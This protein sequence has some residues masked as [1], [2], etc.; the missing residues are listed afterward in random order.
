[1]TPALPLSSSTTAQQLTA[2]LSLSPGSTYHYRLVASNLLATVDGA[3]QAFTIPP[4]PPL[5]RVLKHARLASLLRHGLRLRVSDSS[6][7][8][9]AVKLQVDAESARAAH[10]IPPKSKRKAKVTIG[11]L[12]VTVA[13]NRGKT[14]TVK[15]AGAARRNLA[16]LGRIK[17]TISATA[18]TPNGV[19][20]SP[21]SIAAR[22]VR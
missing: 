18:S 11:S 17:L 19:A 6:R 3:D 15:F 12:R 9:I 4:E 2:T 22:I 14:V 21:T 5:L 13:A 20:G 16:R 1:V 10:L 7:A 8:L